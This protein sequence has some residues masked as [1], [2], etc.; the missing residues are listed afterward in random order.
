MIAINELKNLKINKKYP[1]LI[2]GASGGVGLF[3][4]FILNKL[5]YKIT[6]ATTNIKKIKKN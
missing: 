1:I 5:G 6:A 2:T 4:T 3:S